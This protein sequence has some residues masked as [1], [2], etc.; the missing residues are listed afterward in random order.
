MHNEYFQK[1]SAIRGLSN[2]FLML[3]KQD[4]IENPEKYKTK[5]IYDEED[6][7]GD[8]DE[9]VKADQVFTN[10]N[11]FF[12]ILVRPSPPYTQCNLGEF[13][14]H[15]NLNEFANQNEKFLQNFS[16]LEVKQT[17]SAISNINPENGV[18]LK[19]VDNKTLLDELN[20]FE[21]NQQQNKIDC[22]LAIGTLNSKYEFSK[23]SDK[24]IETFNHQLVFVM[25]KDL[26]SIN[27][28]YESQI[29]KTM[30]NMHDLDF[31]VYPYR[32]DQYEQIFNLYNDIKIGKIDAFMIEEYKL[33]MYFGD[34]YCLQNFIII[35]GSELYSFSTYLY[36]NIKNYSF[37]AKQIS[38]Q[39]QKLNSQKLDVQSAI[40]EQK[41][42]NFSQNKQICQNQ[43]FEKKYFFFCDL[44]IIWICAIFS[45]SQPIRQVM[46]IKNLKFSLKKQDKKQDEQQN[47]KDQQKSNKKNKKKGKVHLKSN[48]LSTNKGQESQFNQTENQQD[49]SQ[50]SQVLIKNEQNIAQN[51]DSNNLFEKKQE[52][53]NQNQSII[54][55]SSFKRNKQQNLQIDI[56]NSNIEKN[57]SNINNNFDQINLQK[58]PETPKIQQNQSYELKSDSEQSIKG[59]KENEQNNYTP[60]QEQKPEQ[61]KFTLNLMSAS[62][63]QNDECEVTENI[64]EQNESQ[65]LNLD[66]PEQNQQNQDEMDQDDEIEYQQQLVKKQSYHDEKQMQISKQQTI[67]HNQQDSQQKIYT[68]INNI[69]NNINNIQ[70]KSQNQQTNLNSN[71]SKKGNNEQNQAKSKVLLVAIYNKDQIN[72]NFPRIYVLFSIYGNIKKMLTIKGYNNLSIIWKFFIEMETIEEAEE[73]KQAL[74]DSIYKQSANLHVFYSN[75]QSIIIDENNKKDF[76]DNSQIE[77]SFEKLYPLAYNKMAEFKKQKTKYG[78]QSQNRQLYVVDKISLIKEY[79]QKQQN[80]RRH[81]YLQEFPDEIIGFLNRK[82]INHVIPVAKS[83]HH[84]SNNNFKKSKEFG[85]NFQNNTN[86]NNNHN[87]NI[88]NKQI[89]HLQQINEVKDKKINDDN[90]FTP[91][92]TPLKKQQLKLTSQISVSKQI[93]SSND[94]V[95]QSVLSRQEESEDIVN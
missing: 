12:E 11:Y 25:E 60:K 24:T 58:Q 40:Q 84:N 20:S 39:L 3:I 41:E 57:S 70:Q 27:E 65:N 85:N 61:N 90:D 8:E 21:Q 6:Q 26:T 23:F 1:F 83:K 59:N 95:L 35:Q 45:I 30:K 13:E 38:G 5:S 17:L 44:I 63:L 56:D 78:Q 74:H 32:E 55:Q 66:N 75:L 22:T 19:C 77:T 7:E 93:I 29:K 10:Q 33:Q 46:K 47:E 82:I 31:Q 64:E 52:T 67:K 69:K 34:D 79:L 2:Y 76:V 4:Y 15:Q 72:V 14:V 91:L 18:L 16:G 68:N 89:Q 28:E 88:E 42:L 54:P 53:S 43:I 81:Y 36:K 37:F 48:T 73:A 92:M 9:Q 87:H 86:G 80:K 62:K 49:L 51:S 94:L 71:Q 50:K